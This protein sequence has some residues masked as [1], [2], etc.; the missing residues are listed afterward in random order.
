[1]SQ[2]LQKRKPVQLSLFEQD[3]VSVSWIMKRWNVSKHTIF[4]LLQSGSL[5][6][7]RITTFGWWRVL[8]N[9]VLEYENKLNNEF[10]NQ[11]QDE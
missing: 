4:R 10:K 6:G 5:R 2:Q 11:A 9:S 7:Y 8:K 3:T 1:M